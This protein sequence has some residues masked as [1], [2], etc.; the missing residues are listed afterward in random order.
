MLFRSETDAL[1]QSGLAEIAVHRGDAA[2]AAMALAGVSTDSAISAHAL[3]RVHR[4][5][6]L[7]N[8]ALVKGSGV[9][10]LATA[11][12]IWTNLGWRHEVASTLALLTGTDPTAARD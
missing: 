3:A 6:G 9:V 11:A 7:I 8:E 5:R 2:S 10:D 1:L 12:Q 4:T